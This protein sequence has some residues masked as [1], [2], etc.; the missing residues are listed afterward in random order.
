LFGEIGSLTKQSNIPLGE[1]FPLQVRDQRKRTRSFL[2]MVQLWL[3]EA[4]APSL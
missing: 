3:N 2:A 1:V 4:L